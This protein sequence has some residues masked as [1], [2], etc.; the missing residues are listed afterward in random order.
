MNKHKKKNRIIETSAKPKIKTKGAREE[1]TVNI[2][3]MM[4]L[5]RD[6][7]ILLEKRGKLTKQITYE[8]N[9]RENT[10]MRILLLVIGVE[11]EYIRTIVHTMKSNK[12]W[13]EKEVEYFV[14]KVFGSRK[15]QIV[16]PDDFEKELI[17]IEKQK[18]EQKRL[19]NDGN[20]LVK[21]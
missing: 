8:T 11:E 16:T 17:S 15:F 19:Y 18:A 14:E 10:F 6:S 9:V 3:Y 7:M 13:W 4:E 5:F 21:P 12:D 2:I 1:I 20:V